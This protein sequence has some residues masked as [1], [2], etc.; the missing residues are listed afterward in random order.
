M[1]TMETDTL[2]LDTDPPMPPRPRTPERER[3]AV[4]IKRYDE[5]KQEAQF[6][7]DA[8]A[9][10]WDDHR[11]ADV[12]LE[13]AK[14]KAK[15]AATP[16]DALLAAEYMGEDV[17]V[18]DG[19]SVKA[20]LD[21]AQAKYDRLRGVRAG[22]ERRIEAAEKELAT[23]Q[24]K[25]DDMV[26]LVITCSPEVADLVEQFERQR[27]AVANM[28]AT[29]MAIGL[30]RMP[31]RD[32]RFG[33]FDPQVQLDTVNLVGD[34]N[35]WLAAIAALEQDADAPLPELRGRSGFGHVFY[36]QALPYQA[37]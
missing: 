5:W 20:V 22:I 15:E 23:A 9:R 12:A 13:A 6:L 19:K 7:H 2:T 18:A 16:N 14:A 36:S 32:N 4:A 25:R 11:A 1:A 3:L 10:A 8:F 29:L 28:Q 17:A 33:K 37:P 34:R 31:P 26:N 21:E 30:A 27:L 35:L 24:R